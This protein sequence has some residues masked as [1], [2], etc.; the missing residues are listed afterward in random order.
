MTDDCPLRVVG[1]CG[2]LRRDS[3]NLA[4]LEE[5]GLQMPVGMHLDIVPWTQVPIYGAIENVDEWPVAVTQLEK[6]MAQA[7]A[8]LIACPEYNFGIPGGFKNALDWLS[9]LPAPP[10]KGQ[11]VALLGA[12]T[13]PL[14]TAR[15]QY[16]LRRVLHCM[17]AHVLAKPEIFV[18][19]AKAKFDAEGRL[20]DEIARNLVKD[21]MQALLLWIHRLRRVKPLP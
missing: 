7:D 16:E 19:N 15:V 3:Y 10:F 21:Q 11:P 9:R 6:A 8:V 20:T 17:D 2:S 4:L 13:G 1:L 12:S 5:A 18:G 14:G